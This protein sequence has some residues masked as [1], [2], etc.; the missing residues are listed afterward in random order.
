VINGDDDL[1]IDS[2]FTERVASA[3]NKTIELID[4]D[5]LK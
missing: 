1:P 2:Q 3:L 4:E 5:D